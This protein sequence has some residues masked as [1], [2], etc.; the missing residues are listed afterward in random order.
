MTV[1]ALRMQINTTAIANSAS[2]R[3]LRRN[4]RAIS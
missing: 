3:L 1:A 2:S 4:L